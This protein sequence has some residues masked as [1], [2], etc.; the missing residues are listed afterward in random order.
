MCVCMC[1]CTGSVAGQ[2]AGFDGGVERHICG[3]CVCVCMCYTCTHVLYMYTDTQKNRH[4]LAHRNTHRHTPL[5]ILTVPMTALPVILPAPL[6]TS[7]VMFTGNIK[8][9]WNM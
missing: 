1:V 5:V 9:M 3:T 8:C 4:T 7:V 2:A 6:T